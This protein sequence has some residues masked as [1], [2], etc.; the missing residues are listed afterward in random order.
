MTKRNRIW[1]YAASLIFVI[2][3]GMMILLKDI[4]VGILFIA[5]GWMFLVIPSSTGTGGTKSKPKL[6]QI[7]AIVVGILLVLL[8]ISGLVFGVP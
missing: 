3:G 6:L 5:I 7:L 4:A 8:L 1:I 2:G